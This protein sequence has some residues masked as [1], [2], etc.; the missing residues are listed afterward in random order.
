M[1]QTNDALLWWR[2]KEDM[3]GWLGQSSEYV[4]PTTK[5]AYISVQPE[6]ARCTYKLERRE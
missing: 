1:G 2:M 6:K 3:T 4:S 5:I